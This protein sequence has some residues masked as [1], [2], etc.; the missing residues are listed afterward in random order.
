MKTRKQWIAMLLML[1]MLFTALP[2]AAFA[3]EVPAD[4]KARIGDTNYES[5]EEAVHASKTGDIIVL[6]AGHYSL[7][8]LTKIQD[9]TAGKDLTFVGQGTDKTF[10]GIGA[11]VPDPTNFGTEFNGDYSFD[12]AGTIT[13]KK[14]TMQSGNADNLGFIRA[15]YT[16]VEDCEIKGRT[17]YWGYKS[18]RF[19][20]T[21]F[22]PGNSNYALWTYASPEMTFDHCTFNSSGKTI[23]VYSDYTANKMD[24][25]VNVKDC[26]VN[27]PDTLPWR[28]KTVLNIND[29]NKGDY[30][31]YIKFSGNNTIKGKVFRDTA[32]PSDE[33][34][35]ATCSRWFGFG[36]K[37][38]LN[39]TG[40]TV[41][42]IDGTTVFE[43]GKMVSHEIDTAK[44][45]YTEGY[46]DNAYDTTDWVDTGDGTQFTH[47]KICKYCKTKVT[48]KG[49]QISYNPDGGSL[50]GSAEIHKEK[51]TPISTQSTILSAPTRSG[52][53]FK[54]W[55]A[56]SGTD[57]QP[58]DN[59][60][61]TNT[62]GE[63]VNAVL[64][65][66]WEKSDDSSTTPPTPGVEMVTVI[67][68]A[69]GGA[70]A[71]GDIRREYRCAPGSVITI[72]SA[73]MREG[74]KFLYW[75]GSEFYPG[76]SYTVPA[77]GH[78][79]TAMWEEE[80]KP[81]EKPSV[82]SKIK[83]PRGNALT[84]DE[85][86]RVL[87]GTKQVIPSIPRAGVGR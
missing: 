74:Y 57:Y 72:E 28:A 46:K 37:Q 1:A 33:S 78:T 27:A 25:T 40:R 26:T 23:N 35:S 60:N 48:E 10:W 24:I 76:E 31:F 22:T 56:A 14:M 52:Y 3:E 44:D 83:T 66:V 86:A 41:V 9:H 73:P 69:N 70:W 5:L 65:A 68:D 80:K 7:Y 62:A 47:D 50:N 17:S 42:T 79:F 38:N 6:G 81:E 39:N 32:K 77:E 54:G 12:G 4:G 21:T 29:S 43:D 67:F 59:Y 53:E 85:I 51:I 61:E 11:E 34:H 75:E 36:G 49:Y 84:A 82:D 8:G 30:K 71:N 13:F 64:T 63:Y 20:N 16:V 45:K 18:A 19:T 2:L 87:S 58:G 55:K 15:D